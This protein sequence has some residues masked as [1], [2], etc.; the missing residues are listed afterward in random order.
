MAKSI[1]IGCDSAAVELKEAVVKRL[2][3]RGWEVED[4]GVETGSDSKAY[5]L[6]AAELCKRIQAGS[7][8]RRGIL[9]CGT[10]IGMAIA[11]NKF[12]GIYAAV[13][14]DIFSAE[15]ASLSNSA[16]VAA[17]GARVVGP[18]L[19]LRLV[20]EWLSLEYKSGPS[21]SKLEAVRNIEADNFK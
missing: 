6:V 21:D 13:I 14:H 4:V 17:L 20:D 16:N 10:G 9:L 3:A 19:A 8:T 11:A 18:H 5:P 7:F 15:R 12:R 2:A 1:L